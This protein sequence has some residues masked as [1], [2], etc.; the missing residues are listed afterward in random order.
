[1]GLSAPETVIWSG[2]VPAAMLY[3]TAM[4]V[5]A[6]YWRLPLVGAKAAAARVISVGNLTLGGNAKTPFTLYLARKLVEH[7]MRTAIASR[8]YGGSRGS[9]PAV[10]VSGGRP[11]LSVEEAGDE[12]VMM[13]RAFDGPLAIARRRL[14]AINLLQQQGE[15]DLVVLDDAF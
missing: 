13:A 11:L 6:G 10:L 5:R 2:L 7:G 15:L 8:G 14:D 4:A 9:G 12:A 3:K 1:S